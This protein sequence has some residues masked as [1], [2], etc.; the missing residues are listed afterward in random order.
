MAPPNTF[1]RACSCTVYSIAPKVSR[2]IRERAKTS[3]LRAIDSALKSPCL[4]AF[5]LPQGAPPAAPC[6]RHTS[7]PRMAGARHCSPLR[8]DLAW[9]LDA[10]C[11][12]QCM[13][14]FSIFSAHP[15]PLGWGADVADDRLPALGDV[16][17]LNRHLLLAAASVSFER[18]GLTQSARNNL[19][20]ALHW[21]P[22]ANAFGRPAGRRARVGSWSNTPCDNLRVGD[23]GSFG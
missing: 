22:G 9:H 11:I 7:R 19:Q 6:I 15:S 8:F 16:D 23:R 21:R 18:L 20:R 2:A 1:L 5:L 4:M 10:R 13:G 12:G 17:M 14:L 3:L